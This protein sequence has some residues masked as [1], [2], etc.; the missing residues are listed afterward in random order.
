MIRGKNVPELLWSPRLL[1]GLFKICHTGPRVS[2][3]LAP[4]VSLRKLSST[5]LR[6]RPMTTAA[7]GRRKPRLR[8]FETRSP[9]LARAASSR[10]TAFERPR[11]KLRSNGSAAAN[12]QSS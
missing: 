5:A 1:R 12:S 10:N 8:P 9:S 3:L 4:A 11:R 2:S 7:R 6:Q